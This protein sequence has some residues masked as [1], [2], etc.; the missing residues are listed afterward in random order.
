[1]TLSLVTR[2]VS[3]FEFAGIV[4]LP[5]S[6]AIFEP[7]EMYLHEVFEDYRAVSKEGGSWHL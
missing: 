6:L 3:G 5:C 2:G 7:Q 1:M 4:Q